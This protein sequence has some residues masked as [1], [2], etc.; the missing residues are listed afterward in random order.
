MGTPSG[1][2]MVMLIDDPENEIG[3]CVRLQIGTAVGLIVGVRVMVGVLVIVGVRDGVGLSVAVGLSVTVGVWDG[4]SVNIG[5]SVG[6][7][8]GV[9]VGISVDV[10]VSVGGL[11]GVLGDRSGVFVTA[12]V[13]LTRMVRA[14][15]PLIGS[16]LAT[17]RSI[18]GT[19]LGMIGRKS[20]LIVTRIR[21]ELLGAK[22]GSELRG[23]AQ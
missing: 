7:G 6:R 2:V 12:I 10:G 9:S 14:L 19:N 11:V 13:M 4:V 1:F 16:P 15:M 18:K 17:E 21:L 22:V 20:P 23:Y 5:V 8:V 3:P